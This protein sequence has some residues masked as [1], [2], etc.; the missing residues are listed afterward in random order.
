[1]VSRQERM[2]A[3][4]ESTCEGEGEATPA[5]QPYLGSRF[6]LPPPSCQPHSTPAFVYPASFHQTHWI[7]TSWGSSIVP[8]VQWELS[9]C[10]M[11]EIVG[12]KKKP[13]KEDTS[14]G[15]RGKRGLKKIHRPVSRKVVTVWGCFQMSFS[16]LKCSSRKIKTNSFSFYSLPLIAPI[17]EVIMDISLQ[18]FSL[19]SGQT[20]S[21][22]KHDSFRPSSFPKRRLP[23]PPVIHY[24]QRYLQSFVFRQERPS[25]SI[26]MERESHGEYVPLEKG[27]CLGTGVSDF[28]AS[29]QDRLRDWLPLLWR[30]MLESVSLWPS[31]YPSILMAAGKVGGDTG[32]PSSQPAG[33]ATSQKLRQ[34][35][36]KPCITFLFPLSIL[37]SSYHLKSSSV[38][39][40]AFS[41]VI[42]NDV[43]DSKRQS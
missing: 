6:L 40:H 19:I 30:D 2:A 26:N 14:P 27:G 38:L 8:G 18:S 24:W 15:Q 41:L 12:K 33:Q 10:W 20:R 25:I 3:I 42:N 34:A 16:I 22:V 1:M 43:R 32:T 31:L 4:L 36:S 5:Q 28:P 35:P 9:K 29:N 21:F 37:L 13:S 23:K 39:T 17:F 11:K 7:G